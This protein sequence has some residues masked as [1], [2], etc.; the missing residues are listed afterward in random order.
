[1]LFLVIQYTIVY[2]IFSHINTRIVDKNGLP[3]NNS[4]STPHL[5]DFQLILTGS[6]NQTCES[7]LCIYFMVIHGGPL[8]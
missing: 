4:T 6:E 1:M 5:D 8:I 2:P 3:E 7:I